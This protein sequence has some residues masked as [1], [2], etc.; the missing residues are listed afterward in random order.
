[1]FIFSSVYDWKSARQQSG[2]FSFFMKKS[3][4]RAV[5]FSRGKEVILWAGRENFGAPRR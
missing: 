1:M 4:W 2:P 3:D 5:A